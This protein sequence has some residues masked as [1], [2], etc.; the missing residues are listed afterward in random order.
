[1]SRPVRF[2][3]EIAGTLVMIQPRTGQGLGESGHPYVRCSDRDCQHVDLNQPPCP[4]R[5]EMFDGTGAQRLIDCLVSA[6]RPICYVC[7][8][9]KLDLTHEIIR[10]LA[11]RLTRETGAAIRPGRCVA[12]ARRRITITVPR[13]SIDTGP[14]ADVPPG[15][16]S[17][18]LE[19][20]AVQEQY[21]RVHVALQTDGSASC[22]ACVAFRVG[23]PLTAVRQAID[24]LFSRGKVALSEGECH[25]C[26]RVHAVARST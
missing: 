7:L 19:E 21:A 24:E 11:L 5:A 15:P 4:L 2:H 25:A 8:G 10:R 14:V 12:C 17:A 26:C 20:P 16:R 3:C 23:L 1:M 6:G 22:A 13:R 9:E 18:L